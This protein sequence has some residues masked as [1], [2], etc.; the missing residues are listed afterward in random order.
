V[1]SWRVCAPLFQAPIHVRVGAVTHGSI[2]LLWE[3]P[4]FDGGLPVQ[5]HVVNMCKLVLNTKNPRA[6]AESVPLPPYTISRWCRV[7][8]VGTHG[9]V[10]EGL[11]P[12]TMYVDITVQCINAVGPG[13]MSVTTPMVKTLGELLNARAQGGWVGWGIQPECLCKCVVWVCAPLWVRAVAQP[14]VGGCFSALTP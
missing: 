9:G 12:D 6:K 11:E 10:V 4:L 8:P 1:V 7:A 13:A 14:G 2:E 3:P 5:D